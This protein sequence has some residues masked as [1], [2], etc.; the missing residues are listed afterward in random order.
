MKLLILTNNLKKGVEITSRVTQKTISL[1]ILTNILLKT[2]KNF[3]KIS[4]T[5]LE[6][7]INFWS[8]AKIEKEGEIAIPGRIFNN[9]LSSIEEEKILLS[10]KNSVF[11][12]KG[13]K[14]ESKIL[15]QETQDFPIIPEVKNEFIEVEALSFLKAL[16]KVFDITATT[17]I[18]PELSGV[19]LSFQKEKIT[20]AASDS[21]RLA[22]KQVFL[23]QE[24]ILE[25]NYQ[26]I[27]P[28]KTARELLNILGERE[29]K[30][31]IYF[32][33]NQIMFE[34]EIPETSHPQL[35]ITSRL[36]E[37][38]YPNYKEIIPQQFQTKVILN[39]A[40]FLEQIKRASLFS[41]K[42]NEIQLQIIP[43]K[44]EVEIFSQNPELGEQRSRIF[45][46][47]KG[48][49]LRISFNYKFLMDALMK[50]N[51]NEIIFQ[52]SSEEGPALMKPS[53]DETYFY[54]VMP[55]KPS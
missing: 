46:K 13:E 32:S 38:S 45:G 48:E 16:S 42:I 21:F 11:Y 54:I 35:Q 50:V 43:R 19:Y 33:P 6:I 30:V 40:E 1:P 15:G 12:I 52:L 28:Q 23:K 34:T 22:E 44:R 7:G 14:F 10:S 47:I 4:A 2:E 9:L 24:N 37:G 39:R 26:I 27:L 8:L 20:M 51:S 49:K 17:Q 18:R 31:K 3:L 53:D 55:I 5:D 36:I 41:G 25:K 29:K